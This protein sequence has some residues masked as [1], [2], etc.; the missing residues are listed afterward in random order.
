MDL[1]T[2]TFLT[3]LFSNNSA[4]LDYIFILITQLGSELFFIIVIPPIYWC[5]DK[6]FGY[7]LLLLS[8]FTAIISSTLKNLFR[9]PRPPERLWKVKDDYSYAFPSGHAHG[10]SSFWL[11]IM[12]YKR[13]LPVIITG[14]TI[15]ILVAISR[16]YLFVH[17][18]RDV[19]AGIALGFATVAIFIFFDKP[20]TRLVTTWGFRQRLVYAIVIPSLLIVYSSLYFN[21]DP[22]GVKVSSALLGI[23]LGSVLETRYLR[24]S[25][26]I[27]LN[28]KMLRTILGL[29]L[30][31]IAYFGLNQIIPFNILTCAFTA[32]LGA[33]TVMFIAPWVFLKLESY[34]ESSI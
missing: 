17:Y 34:I 2:P 23:F 31:Y 25:V 32:W 3:V 21:T 29:A 7:R 1:L 15:I 6:K 14:I 11:Y 26:K 33:F 16:V 5:I 24:F 18:P 10:S 19:L 12:Y 20:I 30:A 27:K 28:G 9:M 8:T 13:Y 22:R 4:I